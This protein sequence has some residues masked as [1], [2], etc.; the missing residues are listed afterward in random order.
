MENCVQHL[1][2]TINENDINSGALK[3]LQVIRPTWKPEKITFKVS[4]R[5]EKIDLLLLN[6][7]IRIL[8]YVIIFNKVNCAVTSSIYLI[9][10]IKITKFIVFCNLFIVF[11]GIIFTLF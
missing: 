4:C 8:N 2:I 5:L 7:V 1:S 11:L 6:H 10:V 9:Q 3:I